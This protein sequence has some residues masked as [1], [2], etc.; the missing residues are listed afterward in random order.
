MSKCRYCAFFSHACTDPDWDVYTDGIIKEIKYWE[1]A[2][3]RINVDTIFF[4][5]GTPSLMP[6]EHVEQIISKIYQCFDVT[7]GAE[8]T[9]ESNPGTIDII[10]MRD[11]MNAG[12]NRISIGVQSL[13]DEKLQYLGRRHSVSDALETIKSAQKL[14]LRVSADFIYGLPNEN[15]RDVIETC[16]KVNSLQLQHCSMYEL[17][18]EP[19]TPIGRENPTMPTNDEMADM[20]NAIGD[21]LTLPRYEV[22][23]YATSDDHCRHNENIWDGAPYIGIGRGAAGR[24][25]HNGIWYEQMGANEKFAPLDGRSRTI[26]KIITGLRTVR[27]VYLTE[28]VKRVI[29]MD[30]VHNMPNLV[31]IQNNRIFVTGAGMLVLDD[32][33]VKIVR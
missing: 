26:E 29:N 28:D 11:F 18:I 6:I 5:G 1:Q 22:S 30:T 3:G 19:T 33:L 17:T 27:G 9:I 24:V 10:K 23:N 20:Y 12:V 16:K 2:L 15:V 13:T 8:T 4:G 32:I 25:Y 21:T 7:P 14:N 31:Q